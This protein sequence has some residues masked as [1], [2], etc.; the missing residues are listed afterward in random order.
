M[1]ELEQKLLKEFKVVDYVDDL[2]S[3]TI[4]K[5]GRWIN[6]FKYQTQRTT[7]TDG[8]NFFNITQIRSGSGYG[9]YNYEEPEVKQ[10]QPKE[11]IITVYE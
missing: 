2:D 3:Y 11:K 5:E 10:V 1:N 7:V 4:V 9:D 8:T 6:N